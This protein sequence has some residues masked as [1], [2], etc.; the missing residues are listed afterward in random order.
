M[1]NEPDSQDSAVPKPKRKPITIDLPAEDIGRRA[2]GGEAVPA[3]SAMP[4]PGDFDPSAEAQADERTSS[5][6]SAGKDEARPPPEQVIPSA[7]AST[8]SGTAS[9][10]PPKWR[11]IP[12]PPPPPPPRR[13]GPMLIAAVAGG[14]I[15]A[16]LVAGLLM[17]GYLGERDGSSL[18]AEVDALKSE[19]IE[20]RQ[21]Q[22]G[23]LAP[24][25]SKLAA[26][27]KSLS[28][29]SQAGADG[30]PDPALGELQNRVAAL[31]QS[32]TTDGST[33]DLDKRVTELGD[34]VAAL[35][36]A[37]PPDAAGLDQALAPVRQEIEALA[38]RVD[39]AATAEEAAAIEQKVTK[40]GGELDVA[41][42]LAPAIAADAMAAALES[43]SPFSSELA[44][45]KDLAVDPGATETLTERAATGLPT[46]A[47]LRSGFETAIA[48]VDL[49]PP[50][51]EATGT[52]ER[53]WLSARGLV[54]VR[55]AHPTEGSDPSAIVTR[56][57]AA[58]AADD[59]KTALAE[60]ESL[61]EASKTATAEWAG[62]AA[63]RLQADDLVAKIRA[64]ALARL[65]AGQ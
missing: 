10:P 27:E 58:L 13:L 7:F 30:T 64:D 36:S 56:I 5:A 61:P 47:Q 63:A 50:I 37:V 12:E 6:S 4:S 18:V 34:A 31:E 24:L 22:P 23:D 42:A 45:V 8:K 44:A 9:P 1:A 21:A 41:T 19:I 59:L 16:A 53:L 14:L 49:S 48:S 17:T 25:E 43:G 39:Q 33:A 15:G 2:P 28:E 65:G 38:A 52:L 3:D 29:L 32:E 46:M 40:I 35:K 60:R 55:P 11:P 62:A 20:L 51:P 57:R 26:L 54:E